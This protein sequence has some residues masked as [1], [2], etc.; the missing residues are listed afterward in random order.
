MKICFN[1]P[2]M[3]KVFGFFNKNIRKIYIV[4]L[5]QLQH[6]FNYFGN[7]VEHKISIHQFKMLKLECYYNMGFTKYFEPSKNFFLILIYLPFI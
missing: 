7:Y 1:N 6:K 5:W 3:P 4:I 2:N